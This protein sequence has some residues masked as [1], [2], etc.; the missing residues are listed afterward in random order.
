M[1]KYLLIFVLLWLL[2]RSF[3]SPRRNQS[4]QASSNR[5]AQRPSKP[6]GTTTLTRVGEPKKKVVDSSDA[7][8][9]HFEEV[10]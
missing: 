9:A 4:N 10:E 8:T 3:R 1:F 6:E 5:S 7:E 2:I